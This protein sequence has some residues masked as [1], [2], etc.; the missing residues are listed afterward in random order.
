MLHCAALRESM[1]FLITGA[2]GFVGQDLIRE[3]GLDGK[4]Q[5]LPFSLRHDDFTL[6]PQD[7]T[8]I[9]HLAGKTG[10]AASWQDPESFY[11]INIE[12]TLKVLEFCRSRK[13]H[14]TLVS[15]CAYGSIAT[16]VSE[17]T[18]L[19]PTN[20]YSHSKKLCE[21]L[22]LF[23]AEFYSVPVSILRVFN[24]FGPGQS[25]DFVIPRIL[26]QIKNQESQIL[27]LKNSDSVRDFIYISDLSSA[28]LHSMQ[29]NLSGIYNVGTG[30]GTSIGDVAQLLQKL[31]GTNKTLQV[32]N[33]YSP[34]EV[35]SMIAN[36][37]KILATGWK[38][39]FSLID[40]LKQLL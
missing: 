36:N 9:V 16:P 32:E 11:K 33:L 17:D 3:A 10:V 19:R 20:P 31:L 1:K 5:A 26:A 21:D 7:I 2:S 28:I 30:H 15:T 22:A 18:P 25:D 12:A 4:L 29:K 6:V 39:R 27:T 24:I 35:K 34:F 8:H 40:G 14:L 38:P 13:L 23:Y 37:S